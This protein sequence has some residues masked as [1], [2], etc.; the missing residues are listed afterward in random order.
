MIISIKGTARL[1][2]RA[3]NRPL[4]ERHRGKETNRITFRITH[5]GQAEAHKQLNHRKESQS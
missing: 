2:R 1:P 3:H 4:S 5:W